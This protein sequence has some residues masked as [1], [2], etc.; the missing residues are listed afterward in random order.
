MKQ[1]RI[2]NKTVGDEKPCFIALEPSA[3]YTNFQEAKQMLQAVAGCGADAVK[4][5]TFF[6]GDGTRMMGERKDIMV[7]F[8]TA[9]G[10]K[11]E[12]V[13]EAFKRRELPKEAWK[14]LVEAAH[15]RNLLFITTAQFLDQIGFL[16]KIGID[17]FKIAKGDV[18]NVLL[19]EAV[20]KTKLPIIIDAREKGNEVT[21]DV[22]ICEREG[23]EQII[24]MHCPSGYPSPDES[25]HLRAIPVMKEMYGYPVGFA[26]HSP[27]DVMNYAAVALGANMIEKTISSN[28]ATE[29]V[30]HF[31]S[32][33][34]EEFQ[35]F[36]RNIRSVQN[37]MGTA[38]VLFT[39]RVGVA[40]R[41]CFVAAR[42]IAPGEVIT[43]E[44]LDFRRPGDAGISCSEG[45]AIL[46]RRAK[47]M[48]R[49]GSFLQ[50]D[51]IE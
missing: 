33:E 24:I 45:Y 38:R 26:D 3:T 19:I 22:E 51:M 34:Q 17:A 11:K 32:L 8:R 31:M 14:E 50:W 9:T 10:E 1:V 16:V 48:I 7:E 41:R 28:K 25:V 39:D 5:Q 27:G 49:A 47:E 4:F 20:A 29:H 15:E 37:A 42:D 46:G 13:Y 40:A 35:K 30:E 12:S 43:V 6:P 2:G 36:V 21:A 23:N 18:N 44:M